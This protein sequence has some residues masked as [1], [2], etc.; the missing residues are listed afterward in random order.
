MKKQLAISLLIILVVIVATVA[1]TGAYFTSKVVTKDSIFTVGTL[2]M[3]VGSDSGAT[4]QPFVIDNI[5][6]NGVNSGTKSWTITNTGTLTGRLFMKLEN[7]KNLENGC[8]G[9]EAAADNTCGNPGVG[10]GELGKLIS[11]KL[12]QND[13]F[14]AESTL[15]EANKETLSNAWGSQAPILL[16]SGK[17]ITIKLGWELSP[18]KYGNEIQSDSLS[19]DVD[20]DL[21]QVTNN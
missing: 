16:E 11:V 4:I 21:S 8:N 7:L 20:F 10:E 1:V 9:P 17:T 15:D 12:F 3:Q 5:G 13:N 18:E 6:A 2:D 19:F 14:V